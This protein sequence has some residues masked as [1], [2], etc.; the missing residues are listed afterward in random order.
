VPDKTTQS[1]ENC[2]REERINRGADPRCRSKVQDG[3]SFKN[4][5]KQFLM[6]T[7]KS[8]EKFTM[9]R[10]TVSRCPLETFDVGQRL[11]ELRKTRFLGLEF[12]R[13][14][15]AAQAAHLD[16]VL[17]VQHFVVKQVL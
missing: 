15:A 12:A 13:V 11:S 4:I 3:Q 14:D 10:R 2:Y 9:A 1:R 8:E 16:R 5:G 7:R 6:A 17:E